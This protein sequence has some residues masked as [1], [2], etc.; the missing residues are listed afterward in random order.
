MEGFAL[1]C[2]AQVVTKALLTHKYNEI[3]CKCVSLKNCTYALS[4]FYS[5]TLIIDLKHLTLAAIVKKGW[6]TIALKVC[7]LEIRLK[8]TDT[9]TLL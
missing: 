1:S 7:L 9:V 5:F 3:K 2:L 6:D 4:P 8:Q